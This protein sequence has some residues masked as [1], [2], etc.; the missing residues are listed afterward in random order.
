MRADF[1]L[2]DA[3]GGPGAPVS[4]LTAA[5]GVCYTEDELEFSIRDRKVTLP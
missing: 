1:Q 5:A 2:T 4:R 3:P